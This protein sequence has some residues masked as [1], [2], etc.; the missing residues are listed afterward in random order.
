MPVAAHSVTELKRSSGIR[1][2]ALQQ[3]VHSTNCMS[4]FS[5]V[6]CR[7]CSNSSAVTLENRNGYLV[8]ARYSEHL[9]I[10]S[11]PKDG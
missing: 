11:H 7:L 3:L 5:R 10:L 2:F 6:I 8:E 9:R 4:V 1:V